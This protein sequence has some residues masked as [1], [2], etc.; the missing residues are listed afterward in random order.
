MAHD[1]GVS[2]ESEN[3]MRGSV[4]GQE[5]KGVGTTDFFDRFPSSDVDLEYARRFMKQPPIDLL[6]V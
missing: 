4:G 5:A 6:D 2:A 1:A 3:V